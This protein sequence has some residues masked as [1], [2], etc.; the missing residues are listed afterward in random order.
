MR[1]ILVVGNFDILHPGHFR[2]LKFAKECGDR[3][4]VAVNSDKRMKNPSQVDQ[5]H[6]LEMILSLECVD[7]AF[8]TDKTPELLVAKHKPWAVVKG[9]EFE[10]CFNPELEALKKYGGKLIFGSGEFEIASE[11]FLNTHKRI[12]STFN[13]SELNDY[14]RRRNI[15]KPELEA[16]FNKVTQFSVAVIGEAIVDEYIQGNA[17]GLSQED[18]TIVMTPSHKETFLGGAAITAGHTKGIGAKKVSLFSVLGDDS[19]G[20]YVKEKINRYDVS[21]FFVTDDSR[22]TPLKTRYRVD[23]KTLLRVNE[24]R[25]HKISVELQNELFDAIAEKISTFDMLVFSDFNYGLLPQQLVDRICRLCDK[26]SVKIVADSQTSSQVGDISRYKNMLLITPTE[27]EV[28]VALNNPDDGLVILAK[29][30]CEKSKPDSLVITLGSEGSF[31]HKPSQS[32][33]EWENDRLPAIN[34]NAID[35]AGAGDCYL[36]T[37][38]LFLAAGATLWQAC[39]VAS[40]AAACQVDT[41]GNSPLSY[42]VLYDTVMDSLN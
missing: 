22:P 4:L 1:N 24:V 40:I 42:Q 30:L 16:L 12:G 3:L 29:K 9:K 20:R 39:Y 19:S 7:Q 21:P 31:I 34:K 14:A 25:Q 38:G 17:V 6:R 13:Y 32:K 15:N 18:P 10:H 23:K 36:A 26:N 37:C 2:L 5:I 33:L 35:P 28:R 27:K 8:L 41:L 11:L